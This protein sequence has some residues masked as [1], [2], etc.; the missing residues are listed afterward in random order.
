MPS[1]PCARE[2]DLEALS[3]NLPQ[4]FGLSARAGREAASSEVV[5][6]HPHMDLLSVRFDGLHLNWGASYNQSPLL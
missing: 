5:N 4:T 1:E 2:R 3:A 6:L